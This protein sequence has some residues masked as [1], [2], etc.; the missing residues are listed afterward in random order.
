MHKSLIERVDHVIR[1]NPGVEAQPPLNLI[2][3][4]AT[5][6]NMDQRGSPEPPNDINPAA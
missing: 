4:S 3:P 6:P 1:T 2:R 5:H